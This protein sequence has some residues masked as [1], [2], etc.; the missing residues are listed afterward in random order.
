LRTPIAGLKTQTELALRQA[1]TAEAR[2]TLTQLRNATE[3]TTRLVNQLLSL[4][5]AEPT[6][7]RA[8]EREPIELVRFARE[9]TA[10]W[11][12]LAL[13]RGVDLGF[14]DPDTPVRIEGDAFQLREM[15]NNVLDNAV[16]YTGPG[17]TVSVRVSVEGGG[18]IAVI[19]VE[20]NGPGIPEADRER[21]FERFYRAL[22]TGVEGCGL[23]LAIVKEIADGHGAT[24]TLGPGAQ[25]RGTRVTIALPATGLPE[26]AAHE[27]VSR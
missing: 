25:G 20:D 8:P 22:G 15:L 6:V 2:A 18:K 12:P 4:A 17:G 24:V 13:A 23:G 19:A 11:V 10:D 7:G 3:Q 5:R 27:A 16:H 14:E 26:R 21:V 1:Q 9:A